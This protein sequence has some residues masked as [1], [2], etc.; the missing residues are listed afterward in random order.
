[1][2]SVLESLAELER[3]REKVRAALAAVGDLRPGALVGRYRRCG[4]ATCHCA[5]PGDPGHGPSWSLTRV[6]GG[7]TRT[8]I[9]PQP[10]VERTQQQIAE[11]RRFRALVREFVELSERICEARLTA[12]DAVSE[13][14]AKKGGSKKPSTLKSS[15]RSRRS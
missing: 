7:K 10:A 6:V 12:D 2:A 3:K 15:P 9:I 14:A 4:K 5:Q 13:E 11:H 1:M 8:K